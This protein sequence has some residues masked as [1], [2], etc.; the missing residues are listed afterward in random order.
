M[1][2]IF[3]GKM[4]AAVT[5]LLFLSGCSGSMDADFGGIF[6]EK[7]PLPPCPSVVA[8]PNADSIT[9]FRDGPGRDLVDVQYEAV[10]TP[11]S[12]ECEY[13]KEFT[14]VQVDLILRIGAVKG[15]A[16]MSQTQDFQ[17]FVA[18][19]DSSKHILNKKIFTSPVEIPDGRRRGAV[20][21]ELAQYIPLPPGRSGEDYSI[22]V[23]FQLTQEQLDYNIK[24]RE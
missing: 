9:V 21:E 3:S 13:Q 12:G 14:A 7:A 2:N 19:A 17:F 10:L 15:P 22:I 16:A 24:S 20:Q 23:G 4:A 6:G 8:L 1:G 5:G 18:I 11:V